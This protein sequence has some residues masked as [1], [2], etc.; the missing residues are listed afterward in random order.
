[1][2]RVVPQLLLTIVLLATVAPSVLAQP[3]ETDTLRVYGRTSWEDG[4]MDRLQLDRGRI[5]GRS[6]AMGGAGLA[7]RGGA[8]TAALN[9]ASILGVTR[10]ELSAE[11]TLNAG[12]AGVD[13]FPSV[14]VFTPETV[15]EARNYR[16]NP[17]ADVSYNHVS[18]GMPLVL[19]GKR[20]AAALAYRRVA[21][22]GSQDET[23]VELRGPVT[24]GADATFGIGDQPE[25]GL[26]VISLSIA[27]EMTGFLNLGANF[28]WY[29]GTFDRE[30]EIGVSSFG[31]QIFG[32]NTQFTQDASAFN[33]D[34]GADAQFGKLSLAATS[35]FGY[36]IQFDPTRSRT[37]PLPPDPTDPTQLLYILTDHPGHT[38][39]VPVIFGLGASYEVND[40]LLV[41]ADYWIRPWSTSSITRQRVDP[42]IGFTDLSDSSSYFF[43]LDPVEGETER[44]DPRMEDTN[45]FRVGVEWKAKKSENFELPLRLGFRTEK[46][47]QANIVIPENIADQQGSYPGLVNEYFIAI[48]AGDTQRAQ[49]LQTELEDIAEFGQLLFRGDGVR[50]NVITAGIGVRV[51]S[52]SADLTFESVRYD[53]SRFFLQPFDPLLNPVAATTQE[54]RSLLNISLQ[55]TMR[56]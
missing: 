8:Q 56:F 39:S 38:L 45:S 37:S 3:T 49:Q 17:R 25:Q 7:V 52:F 46:T 53:W 2:R 55:T 14:L 36:N 5:G 12:G 22:T 10:P 29:S 26:D 18:F 23:R 15:L 6:I 32:G 33:L 51:Q 47:T 42:I 24:Q 50:T 21:R 9:P 19:L 11:A 20:G 43:V 48:N 35:Y 41:A 31:F 13:A 27:R 34:V 44:I 16:V 40:R 4:F 30:I 28:N 1:M 54:T